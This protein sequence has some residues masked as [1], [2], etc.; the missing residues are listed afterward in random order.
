MEYC[1]AECL[2]MRIFA[3]RI[4]RK[5][6]TFSTNKCENLNAHFLEKPM[7]RGQCDLLRDDDWSRRCG[8]G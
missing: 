7:I 1:D 3:E 5:Q 8:E 4:P 2:L 6:Q